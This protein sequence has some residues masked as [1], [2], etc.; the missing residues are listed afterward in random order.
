MQWSPEAGA[1]ACEFCGGRQVVAVEPRDIAEYAIDEALSRGGARGLDRPVHR[2]RC[3]H[4]GAVM[5][6]DPGVVSGRCAF[7][8]TP[9]VV[10][11]EAKSELWRPESVLPFTVSKDAAVQAYREWLKGL[12]FRPNDL[13]RRAELQD[14]QGFY[15]PFWTYDA[16]ADAWWTAEAG[17]YYYDTESYTD[18]QG[19][20]Q[21]RQVR[22]VRWE[23]V[24]GRLSEDFDD[25]L[26]YASRGLPRALCQAI[27]PFPTG[28]LVPYDGRYLAG[29]GAEEYAL[30][31]KE[32][33]QLAQARMHEALTRACAARVPGD[34][35]RNLQVRASFSDARFKH[36]L[37]P[38]WVA[39]Y[40]YG[41]DS[42]RFL[43]NGRTGEVQ[44]TAP[45]SW[46]KITLA[47]L[48]ALVLVFVLYT[49]A[50]RS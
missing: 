19:N 32:G 26:I 35:Q 9:G 15:L 49:L 17:Y 18:A 43:V 44:G 21:T 34:T 33:W 39:A 42:Y 3:N 1:L 38:I 6:L 45:W 41:A 7:C 37:L 30:D 20:R 5:E 11:V 13:K 25:V 29:F 36:V 46:V 4:C 40:R 50:G 23:R 10:E 12:W 14:I 47:V 24:S 22:K 31:A 28:E 48:A 8:D 16:H 27:E 2:V